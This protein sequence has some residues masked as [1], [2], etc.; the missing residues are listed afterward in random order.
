MMET[1][2]Q[3]IRYAARMGA[4]VGRFL[5]G[6]FRAGCSVMTLKSSFA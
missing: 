6:Q 4:F 5:I 2:W 3:D 1:L